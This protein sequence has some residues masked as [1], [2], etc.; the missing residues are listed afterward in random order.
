M[1]DDHLTKY[2]QQQKIESTLVF[3]STNG[4][5]DKTKYVL[6]F[7]GKLG[8]VNLA[9]NN[10]EFNPLC[11]VKIGQQIFIKVNAQGYDGKE[12]NGQMVSAA[13]G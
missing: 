13:A 12:A 2:Q 3:N 9:L 6:A 8:D 5:Q 10:L 7:Y 4:M 11:P 1:S